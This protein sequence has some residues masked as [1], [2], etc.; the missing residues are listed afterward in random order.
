M[1]S[2]QFQLVAELPF[3][4]GAIGQGVKFTPEEATEFAADISSCVQPLSN[5]KTAN[6]VDGRGI[7]SLA[8]GSEDPHQLEK[9]VVQTLPGGLGLA[10]TKAAV[11]ADLV[12]VRDAKDFKSAYLTV[13]DLLTELGYQDGGHA[14][15]GASKQ[16]EASVAREV[17]PQTKL[18]VLPALN[19]TNQDTPDVLAD[20][21]Q[22]KRQR[23]ENGFYGSW[24]SSWHESFLAERSPGNFAILEGDPL[25]PTDNH[26]EEGAALIRTPGLGFAK[27][28][29]VAITG[30]RQVFVETVTTGH[31]IAAKII[32]KI[33]GSDLEKARFLL[34][35]DDDTLQVLNTLAAQGLPAFAEAA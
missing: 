33:G 30:G 25:S 24:D 35:F 27:N 7:K 19:L 21:W 17:D 14:A 2:P 26:L 32:S 22:T 12:V 31:S 23:L 29:F 34:E 5:T 10:V 13:S 18:A 28:R 6:C 11:A 20:N 3:G 15:C 1:Q 8:D 16:L 9:Y 4:E